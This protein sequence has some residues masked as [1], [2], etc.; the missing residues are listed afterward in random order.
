MGQI[1]ADRM[2]CLS[3]DEIMLKSHDKLWKIN[4][5]YTFLTLFLL[6]A[7]KCAS[8]Q[9]QKKIVIGPSI[10]NHVEF[11]FINWPTARTPNHFAV[12][13][14]KANYFVETFMNKFHFT[15]VPCS[16]FLFSVFTQYSVDDRTNLTTTSSKQVFPNRVYHRSLSKIFFKGKIFNLDWNWFFVRFSLMFFF[17]KRSLCLADE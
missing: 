12:N 14:P 13:W 5:C 15:K 16:I 11:T 3:F 9:K 17:I 1:K 4:N 10:H 8:F 2:K 7:K 6:N